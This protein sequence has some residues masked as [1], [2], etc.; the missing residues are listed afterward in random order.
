MC[1]CHGCMALEKRIEGEEDDDKGVMREGG[2]KPSH[3]YVRVRD[4]AY[5][6]NF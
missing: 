6:C 3:V 2:E 1:M 4:C 5:V